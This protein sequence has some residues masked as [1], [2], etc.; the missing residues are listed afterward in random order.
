MW[1]RWDGWTPEKGFND[2]GMNSYNHYAYGAIGEWMYSTI[3]GIDLDFLHPG[4][5]HILIRPTPGGG[6]THARAK[7]R[8]MHGE[9]ESSWRVE[10]STLNLNVTIP[11]N[12][13]ATIHIPTTDQNAITEGGQPLAQATGLTVARVDANFA[14][15]TCGAGR[16]EFRSPL[17]DPS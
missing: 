12:T 5:K 2:A 3:A 10:G 14:V 11:P 8:S 6:L 4:Y 1:E 16:Y 13:T 15:I 9:I 17:P 7:L